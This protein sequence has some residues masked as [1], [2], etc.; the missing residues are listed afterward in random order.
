MLCWRPRRR[1]RHG[2][3]ERRT[4]AR[5]PGEG[6][7]R[8]GRQR[9]ARPGQ[10]R[11]AGALGRARGHLR[12]AEGSAGAGRRRDP[13]G[14]RRRRP[15]P[16]DRRHPRP[17]GRGLRR[18]HGGPLRRHRH[19]RQQRGHLGRRRLRGDRRARLAGRHRPQAHGGD[20]VLPPRHPA[21]EAARGRPHRQRHHGG[22]Q[23]ARG[24]IA[25]H[26]RHA[27]GGDQPH[28]GARQRVRRRR[29][30]G[31]HD[32]SRRREERAVGAPPHRRPGG[33]LPR[34]GPDPAHPARS[35]RGGPRVRRPG[36]LPLLGPRYVHHRHGD[37][38]RWRPLGHRV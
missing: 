17:G 32:L 38:L 22:R 30:P 37:Q 35:R 9:G 27:R 10:R 26:H 13:R 25:A 3:R 2:P 12:P 1:S 5:T 19:P 34:G 8:D 18:G 15:G 29:D 36:G 6:R 4:R 33:L 14:D 20:P 31:E 16:A 24:A 28:Q 23:G 11:A 21:H 7:H